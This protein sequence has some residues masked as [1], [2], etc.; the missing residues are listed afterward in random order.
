MPYCSHHQGSNERYTQV[1]SNHWRTIQWLSICKWAALPNSVQLYRCQTKNLERGL[2]CARTFMVMIPCKVLCWDAC[3]KI[4]YPAFIFNY[5]VFIVIRIQQ[6]TMNEKT[7][8]LEGWVISGD[9]DIKRLTR[10]V[11]LGWSQDFNCVAFPV[12]E[13]SCNSVDSPEEFLAA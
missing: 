2:C 7:I 11:F 1:N 5:S 10:V 9:D 3:S 4:M 6:L 12:N 13:G 8:V